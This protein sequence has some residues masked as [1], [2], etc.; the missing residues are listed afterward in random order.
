MA[1]AIYVSSLIKPLQTRQLVMIIP[2]Y[3][4]L[5]HGITHTSPRFTFC[6]SAVRLYAARNCDTLGISSGMGLALT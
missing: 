5:A 1:K 4:P 2:G 6:T 3:G